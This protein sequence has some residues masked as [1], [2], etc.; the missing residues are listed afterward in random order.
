MIVV[1]VAAN[2][3]NTLAKTAPSSAGS[4]PYVAVKSPSA[5][6][7]RPTQAGATRTG[8]QGHSPRR[9]FGQTG[10]CP[11]SDAA[12]SIPRKGVRPCAGCKARSGPKNRRLRRARPSR[13]RQR[14]KTVTALIASAVL[15][16]VQT[17]G[18]AMMKSTVTDTNQ[19]MNW[20]VRVA[21]S[22]SYEILI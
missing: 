16:D 13:R 6:R 4:A 22:Y 11:R 12:T 20:Q 8:R 14:P 21:R 18:G 9:Q 15:L 1:R 19:G 10:R 17:S 7:S 3:S 2:L 5:G